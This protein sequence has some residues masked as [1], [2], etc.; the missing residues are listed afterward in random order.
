MQAHRVIRL[1]VSLVLLAILVL[2]G[3][4]PIQQSATTDAPAPEVAPL[5]GNL[6]DHSHAITTQSELTQQYFNEGLILTY[7]FNHAL[8][9]QSFQNG[10]TLDPNCAMCYWGIAYAL[11][12]NINAPMD[13]AAVP[14]AWAALQKALE[15]APN[16]SEVE[17][18]YIQALATRYS[19]DPNADR[20]ALDLAYANAMRELTQRYPEDADAMALFAE[21][22]MDLTPWN[23]WSKEGE[24]TEYT[25]EILATL[26]AALALDPNHPGANHF[27]I[28][29]TEASMDPGRALPSAQRL[30]S[31]VPGAGH[32]RHM[33][34][35]TY[36]RVGMYAD[37]ARVNEQAITTDESTV[38][39]TPD[40]RTHGFYAL[41]Y[42][43]HNIHFLST[44][45]Q[46]GGRSQAAI[47][48]ARKVAETIPDEAVAAVPPLQD[49]DSI[50]FFALV[51]FGK[52]DEILA[53]PQ[54]LAEHQYTTGIWHWAR[55]MAYVATGALDEAQ[56][57]YDAVMA[58]AQ[59][60]E[61]KELG[62]PSFSTGAINL[63]LAGH[64][65]AADLA[66]A[67]GDTD[68]QIAELEAAV[69]LQDGMPYIEPP[70][71]YYP[72]RHMLG[73]ALLAAERPAEAEAV[74]RAD[75][76]QYPENGWSLFGLMKS[77]E[78]QGNTAEATEVQQ[79]FEQVWES[80]DVTL[81]TT[82]F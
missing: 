74:Y 42:Y 3:C 29:A 17:Q 7:G 32:L 70:A 81:T 48:T 60:E 5:L 16:A 35:H 6:G 51:R 52:W 71:W 23:Y 28:H 8:A 21:A 43:P 50:P 77:L 11:G 45:A 40:D 38:G 66:G 18:A 64:I 55:G 63:E 57:E 14:E 80:A 15:L 82:R 56:S 31:L 41:A 75:L 47:V 65:L 78:A 54:P 1:S 72:V 19:E 62:L 24:A 30:E 27:Y 61:M 46:M 53:E 26:E 36:W 13:P 76:Q 49:F 34:A 33:P 79:Q 22:L 59:S 67:A 12:P 39:G 10:L 4:Q 9:I 69:Q 37:A 25:E 2:A 44:A 73:A 58:L 68:K 20:A